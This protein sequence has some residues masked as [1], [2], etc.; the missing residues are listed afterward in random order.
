MGSIPRAANKSPSTLRIYLE[1]ATLLGTFIGEPDVRTVRRRNVEE[2]ID[3][4]LARL[5]PA[6]ASSRYRA[7]RVWFGWLVTEGEIA[8]SPMDGMRPPKVPEAPVPVLTDDQVERLFK[9]CGGTDFED[10]RDM[11]ILR[12]FADTGMRRAELANLRM[13]DVD[14]DGQIATVLG[15]GSRVRLCPYGDATSVALDR[16]LRERARRADAGSERLWLGHLGPLSPDGIRRIVDRRATLAGLR[17]HPHLFRHTFAHR[18]LSD[19]G[20][21]GDLMALG[22]WRSREVMGRYG[23][24]AATARA[25]D[26][27]RRLRS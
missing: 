18:W 19:G 11:A 15:K 23:R 2:F 9:T 26:A 3:D 25:I 13:A 27:Y 20:N 7:L 6:S 17:V 5:K 4:Q 22:G 1:A 21:E 14:R 24:G 8:K 10:R 12:M 16:Y